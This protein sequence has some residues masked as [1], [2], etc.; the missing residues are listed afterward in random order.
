MGSF[1]VLTRKDTV[2]GPSKVVLEDDVVSG[3]TGE[4][5]EL[6]YLFFLFID[7]SFELDNTTSRENSL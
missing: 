6:W 7:A 5:S 3:D 2:D 1:P 4:S